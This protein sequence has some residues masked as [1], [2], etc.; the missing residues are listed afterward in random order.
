MQPSVFGSDASVVVQPQDPE[1]KGAS[2]R[3]ADAA[4]AAGGESDQAT[5][6]GTASSLLLALT[7]RR[8][9][10]GAGVQIAGDRALWDRWLAATPF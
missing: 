2:W 6:N 8:T 10:E 3:L 5:V 4:R 1:L 7:R 9:A